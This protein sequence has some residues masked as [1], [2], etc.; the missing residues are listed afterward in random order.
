M[1]SNTADFSFFWADSNGSNELHLHDKT[2]DEAFKEAMNFGFK[3]MR[4][5]KPSTW[6]NCVVMRDGSKFSVIKN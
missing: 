3:P 6:G 1:E 4:W 5:W 2:R